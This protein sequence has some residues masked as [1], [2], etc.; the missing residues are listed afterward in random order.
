M[1]PNDRQPCAQI[2]VYCNRVPAAIITNIH[3]RTPVHKRTRDNFLRDE[4]QR[5]IKSR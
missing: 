4:I 5:R 2:R 1:T 3:S